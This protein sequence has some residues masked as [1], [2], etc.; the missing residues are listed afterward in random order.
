VDEWLGVEGS[1]RG[2]AERLVALAAAS[3]SFDRVAALREEFGGLQVTDDT[4]RRH[5]LETGRRLRE[6]QR[7]APEVPQRFPQAT[8]AVAFSTDGPSVHTLQGWRE[9]RLAVLA[10]R[11]AGPAATPEQREGDERELP[12]PSARV[13][14]GGVWGTEPYGP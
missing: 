10:Q 2:Q 1:L 13:L 9:L 7:H 5:R 4:I 11:Q 14:F 3:G 6:W 12:A 8:G